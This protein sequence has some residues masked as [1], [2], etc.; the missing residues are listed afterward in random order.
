MPLNFKGDQKQGKCAKLSDP[1]ET[2]LETF[3]HNLG[4]LVVF[5]NRKV[6]HVLVENL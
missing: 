5:E 6:S 2:N 1:S 4:N 3:K